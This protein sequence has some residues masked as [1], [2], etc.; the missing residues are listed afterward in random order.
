[1]E[2]V[3]DNGKRNAPTRVR[4]K[5]PVSYNEV[6]KNTYTFIMPAAPVTIQ[7]T[8]GVKTGIDDIEAVSAPQPTRYYDL[9]GRYVGTSL[10]VLAPGLYL[11]HDGRKVFVKR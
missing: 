11:T 2:L 10:N 7:A 1:M 3:I 9:G 4:A 5:A 6:D 8:F